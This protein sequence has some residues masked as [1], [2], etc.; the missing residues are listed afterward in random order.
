MISSRHAPSH[1]RAS[2]SLSLS[3]S[4]AFSPS[5]RL[6]GPS[7]LRRREE[8][9]AMPPVTQS[10][11]ATQRG[12]LNVCFSLK[13][14]SS[15]RSC[16]TVASNLCIIIISRPLLCPSVGRWV[17]ECTFYPFSR[18]MSVWLRVRKGV[19][20]SPPERTARRRGGRG[21]DSPNAYDLRKKSRA[22]YVVL[23]RYKNWKT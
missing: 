4:L 22:L 13:S 16:R 23:L 17:S 19:N 7:V 3:L 5:H 1:F 20:S 10:D 11:K 6:G 2:L 12:Q 8:K 18:L 15:S 14:S 21:R 9:G